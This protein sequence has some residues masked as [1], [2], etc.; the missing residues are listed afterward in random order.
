MN[1]DKNKQIDDI[2]DSL[3]SVRRAT[4]PDFFYT[5][6]KSRME[7]ELLKPAPIRKIFRPAFIF[8]GLL[9]L[10]LMN[11]AV[12]LTR[13]DN[14]V[15]PNAEPDLQSF[16]MEYNLTENNPALFDLNQDK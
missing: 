13:N 6:L 3:D 11:V 5:R 7:K 1:T 8:T 12:I 15:T 9:L 2:L 10:L 14:T 4:T 16:A